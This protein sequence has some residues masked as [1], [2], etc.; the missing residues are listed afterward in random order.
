MNEVGKQFQ[1][2]LVTNDK[3]GLVVVNTGIINKFPLLILLLNILLNLLSKNLKIVSL[4][5]IMKN[6]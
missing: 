4:L 3:N 5:Q 6:L 2:M 1:G